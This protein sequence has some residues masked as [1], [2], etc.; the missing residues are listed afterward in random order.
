VP[1]HGANR[2]RPTNRKGVDMNKVSGIYRI[3]LG[4][5]YFYIGSAAN[6]N[7]RKRQH[8]NNLLRCEHKNRIVQSCW[9]KYQIFEFTVLQ[10]CNKEELLICEQHFLDQH[11]E[12]KKNANILKI[13]GNSTGLIHSAE[14]RAKLSE[15]KQNISEKTRER[16]SNSGKNKIFSEEHRAKLCE[17]HKKRPPHSSETRKKIAQA[18]QLAW[19]EGRRRAG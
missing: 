4:N 18:Q 10:Y 14:T 2:Q 6:L 17:A 11:F 3:E 7:K 8:Q 9:N 12:N 1:L 13:A 19:A 15:A 5:G 16:M